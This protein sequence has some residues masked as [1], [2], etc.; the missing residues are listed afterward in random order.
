[1]I[2]METSE[3]P[4]SYIW[5]KYRPVILRLMVNAEDAAQQYVFS[6]HEFTRMFPKNRGSL[7]FVLY[8]HRSRALNNI[9]TSPLAQALLG[10]LQQ[11]A[12]A[13]KLSQDSTY[14]LSLDKHFVFHVRKTTV[15]L[16]GDMS[17]DVPLDRQNSSEN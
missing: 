4:C 15:A 12:T 3:A 5:H 7:A 11:S 2:N 6:N 9:K 8:I 17:S 16:E 10:I 13:V 1:M 14:E